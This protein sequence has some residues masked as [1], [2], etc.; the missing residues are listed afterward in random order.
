MGLGNQTAYY[1]SSKICF[2][3]DLLGP[4]LRLIFSSTVVLSEW[5]SF[6]TE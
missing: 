3:L 5:I 6:C 1:L 2:Y 4:H